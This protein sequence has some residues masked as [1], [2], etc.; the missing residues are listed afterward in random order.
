M[1]MHRCIGKL[2]LMFT[3]TWACTLDIFYFTYAE[4][5]LS[6]KELKYEMLQVFHVHVSGSIQL[7]DIQMISVYLPNRKKVVQYNQINAL[8]KVNS[9]P[10]I[11]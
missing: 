7:S 8:A 3:C 10:L 1:Y 4:M 9:L 2:F 5:A 11:F 6:I